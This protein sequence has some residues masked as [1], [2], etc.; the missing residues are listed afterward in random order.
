MGQCAWLPPP[1]VI[2]P[3][4]L[5]FYTQVEEFLALLEQLAQ[6]QAELRGNINAPQYALPFLQPGRLVSHARPVVA[7]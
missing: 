4:A 7:W 2:Y 3:A 5:P 6:L 1:K